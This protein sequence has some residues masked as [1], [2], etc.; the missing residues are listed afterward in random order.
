[1]IQVI[2]SH[3][4]GTWWSFVWFIWLASQVTSAWF[5]EL[6]SVA[7]RFIWPCLFLLGAEW[8]KWLLNLA[9][10]GYFLPD[11]QQLRTAWMF[12]CQLCGAEPSLL[13]TLDPTTSWL[14]SLP[15]CPTGQTWQPCSSVPSIL[16]RSLSVFQPG[17]KW[18]VWCG[19][20]CC[21]FYIASYTKGAQR[22]VDPWGF[23]SLYLC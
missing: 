5:H 15:G 6:Y 10:M 16:T 22:L 21:N 13:R 3:G 2:S 18:N 20:R 23:V 11:A 8:A 9:S 4:E 17:T 19:Y 14:K 7:V 1:M 12:W